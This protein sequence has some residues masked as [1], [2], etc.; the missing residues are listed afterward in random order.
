VEEVTDRTKEPTRVRDTQTGCTAGSTDTDHCANSKCDVTIGDKT[1]CSQC[2]TGYVPINGKCV[3]FSDS[4]VTTTA[5][6]TKNNGDPVDE[7]STTCGKCT[8]NNYFLFMGGCYSQAKAPGNK[9]CTT[10]SGGR[11]TTCKT[12]SGLFQNPAAS[13]T[14]GSECILCSDA[15]GANGVTGVENC[16]TCTA[17]GQAGPATCDTCQEGY[18]EDGDACTKCHTDCATCSESG[19]SVCTSC[20]EGKYLKT[21]QCIDSTTTQCDQGTYADKRTRTCKACSEIAGCTAC[22]YNDNLGGPVCSTC[23]G[24]NNL[25]KTAI[26]GS[27]TCVAAAQCAVASQPGTHFLNKD[28]NGCILCSNA[29]D[30]TP[31]NQGVANCKTCTK[32]TDANTNPT[33]SACLDG[34]YISSGS[35]AKCAANCATCTSADMSTCSKCLPGYFLKTGSTNECVPCGDVDKGGREGCAACSNDL[36]FKCAD[37]RANYRKQQNGGASD[38]YTCTKTCEDETACGGTAGACRAIVVDG[39]GS[40]KYYCS[41][42]G[43]SNYVPIDGKC[44]DSSSANGNQCSN[45]ACQSCAANY[46]LYMGGCYNT[47]TTPGSLM[48]SKATTAGVCDTPNAN[49]RYFLVPGAKVTD[50]SVL[51]CGNPLGTTT[52]TGDTAKAYVGIQG[53]KTCTAPSEASNGAMAAAK[54]TACDEGTA[55]TGS[56]YGCVTCDIAGCSACRADNMCEACSDGYRLEGDTCVRTGGNLSTGAIAGISVAAVVV[57]GGLV[58]FL[59]WWFICRGKA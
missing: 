29:D 45:G 35:C 32:S 27:T 5:G 37:C 41:S 18:Y 57:V 20:P 42:C 33:C 28:N 30:T 59:C 8:G 10:A 12:A 25:V 11:C 3:A 52:G 15:T 49:S 53:C 17:P 2:A 16:N 56:G 47:Q 38:D 54:C 39:D 31:G 55:L 9:V 26:D 48:C 51:G 40:M 1:Y 21:N 24:S 50:Q 58:G 43:Q 19:A 13:P 14:L 44:V 22:A 23:S 34:Y 46:F 4:S 7:S 36:T 6:C